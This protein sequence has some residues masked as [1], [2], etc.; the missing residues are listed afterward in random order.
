MKLSEYKSD[1]YQYSGLASSATR[2]LALAGIAL[3]WVFKTQSDNGTYILP[4]TLIY[5]AIGLI[6]SLGSDLLQYVF[7]TVIWGLFHRYHESLRESIEDDPILEAPV[8][9][10]WPINF[11]FYTKI[12]AVL[13]SYFFLLIFAIDSVKFN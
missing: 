10:T 8:H 9:Y 11:F 4:N 5:P 6:V 13:V 12:I 2:Q 3:I 7:G 1:Y